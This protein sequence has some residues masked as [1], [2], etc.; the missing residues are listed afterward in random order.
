MTELNGAFDVLRPVLERLPDSEP[1]LTMPDCAAAWQ[2]LHSF[3]RSLFA[4]WKGDVRKRCGVPA[5]KAIDALIESAP[6]AWGEPESLAE[7]I[8]PLPYPL[9]A[10]PPAFRAPVEEVRDFVQAPAALVA[11]SALSAVSAAVQG[12]ANVRRDA[13]LVGPVS[14]YT[15]AVADSGER[16]TSCDEFF[17]R[18]LREWERDA[19]AAMQQ[20]VARAAADQAAFEA[21]RAGIQDAIKRAAR[22]GKDTAT[23]EG[24]LRELQAH[25][26]DGVIVPRLL[27][28]DATPEA[29]AFELARG[30]PCGAMLSAEAGAIL[31][32]HAM[33]AD[34]LMRNLALLNTLWDG[35]ELRVDRRT[36]DGFTIR[37]RRLTFGVMIQEATL[38]DFIERTRG[39]ARGT[40]F[41]ARFLMCW[42]ASTQGTRAYRPAPERMPA[43]EGFARRIRVLL[44]E[45]PLR[46]SVV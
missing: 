23:L 1:E 45:I 24:S 17:T 6:V 31:G 32:G 27:Y 15:L 34:T 30:W 26:P 20:E 39:L 9:E 40:G 46:K 19:A 2:T 36:K 35:G 41:L 7:R 5:A 29:L 11:C 43:L 18:A 13:Q 42:P 38:R 8:D 12:L 37:G 25:A 33:S 10:L 14:T 22:A 21:K 3:D 28:A 4:S 44:D 16:K